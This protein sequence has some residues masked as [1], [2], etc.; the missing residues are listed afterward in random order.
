M[1]AVYVCSLKSHSVSF[2]RKKNTQPRTRASVETAPSTTPL[3]HALAGQNFKSN[4][5]KIE[6][7]INVFSHPG[8]YE[9]RKTVEKKW[10]VFRSLRVH[11]INHTFDDILN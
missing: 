11:I 3:S 6:Y 5:G 4:I 1:C 10:M 8:V 7:D 2:L 9:G